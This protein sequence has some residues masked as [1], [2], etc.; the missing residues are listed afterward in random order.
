MSLMRWEGRIVT[1]MAVLLGS[2][3]LGACNAGTGPDEPVTP[4][5][6]GNWAGEPFSGDASAVLVPGDADGDTLVMFGAQPVGGVPDLVVRVV[7]VIDGAGTYV[8]GGPDA[9]VVFYLTGGDVVSSTYRA[10]GP[11]SVTLEI[12]G[13]DGPG[14]VITGRVSFEAASFS[15]AE[16][17]GPS[18]GFEN[19]QFRAILGYLQPSPAN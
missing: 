3:A 19:G 2:L 5:F 11:E 14:G 9:A 10:E 4:T 1:A 17:V 12:T 15:G 18:A 16:P 7:A 6:T 8:L 13:F